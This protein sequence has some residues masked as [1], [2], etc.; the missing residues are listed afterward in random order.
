MLIYANFNFI[1]VGGLLVGLI[2]N[3]ST[4]VPNWN[5]GFGLILAKLNLKHFLKQLENK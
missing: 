5:W 4:S 2:G 3:I 1:W